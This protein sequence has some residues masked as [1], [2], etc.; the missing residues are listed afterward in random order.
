[1][2]A[3]FCIFVKF[4]M[5]TALNCNLMS[6]LSTWSYQVPYGGSGGERDCIWLMVQIRKALHNST[7][8]CLSHH[9]V[10]SSW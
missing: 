7:A 8:S 3:H 10:Y 9:R 1:M 2:W 5:L 4:K 6:S